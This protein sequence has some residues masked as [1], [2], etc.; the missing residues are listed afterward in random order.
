[1]RQASDRCGRDDGAGRRVARA[2][3]PPPPLVLAALALNPPPS[4][5]QSAPFAVIAPDEAAVTG[6]SGALPPPEIAPGDDPAALTFID[7]NGPSLRIVDLRAMGGP[8]SAQVVGAPKPFTFPRRADRAG[9]RRRARRCGAAERLCRGVVGL[10]AADRRA[11]AGRAPPA[12]PRRRPECGFHGR[13]LGRRRRSGLDL[14]DRR[15]DGP[16][17]QVRRRDDRRPAEFGGRARRPRLR[18]EVAVALRRRP[19]ERPHPSLRNGW[20]RA[21]QSTITGSPAAPPRGFRPRPGP[22]RRPSTLRTRNSTAAIPRPGISPSPE[23]RVFGLA[24]HDGRLYYAVADSLQVWSVGLMPDGAPGAD[25]IIE[26]MAPPA[27]GPTEISKIAFDGQGRML[28]AERAAP[29][30]AFDFEALAAPGIGRALRYAIVGAAAGRRVWQESPDEYA[31]GLSRR[32]SQRRRRRRRRRQLRPPRQCHRG[33]LRRVRLD[34]GRGPARLGRRGARG[35]ARDNG[36]RG[37]LRAAGGRRLADAAPERAAARKLFCQ[38][39]RRAARRHGARADGRHRDPQDLR[40][41]LERVSAARHAAARSCRRAAAGRLAART[42]AR[43]TSVAAAATAACAAPRRRRRAPAG[44]TRSGGSATAA[45]RPTCPRR[46]RPGR[47]PL[48]PGRDALGQ[49]R[50]ARIRAARRARPRSGRATSAATRARSMRGR[51]A[52]RP[53]ARARSSTGNAPAAAARADLSAR[54]SADRGMPVPERLRSDRRVVL[55]CE[56]GDL[57]RRLLPGGRVARRPEQEPVPA[58]FPYSDRPLVLRL[59]LDPDGERR[60]LRAGQRDDRRRLLS[61]PVDPAN[62]GS[63]P[64]QIQSRPVCAAGY[65]AMPDGTCCN[66]RFVG[67]DG[68]DVPDRAAAVR[69]GRNAGREG[70]LRPSRALPRR[71]PPRRR[72]SRRPPARPAKR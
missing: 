16:R 2:P 54:R 15:R 12:R 34:V 53:A 36:A 37:S 51:A 26:L 68:R 31:L 69:P 19:R 57:E 20:E 1:M 45:A 63:C 18:S 4:L 49:A 50:N 64:I 70:R 22:R 5:A 66:R 3:S 43:R 52:R 13:S 6:F 62:R 8:A 28:L 46:R 10:W 25:A 35:A 67:A 24:V 14:E 60:V 17:Q 32:L 41:R 21:W 55:P 33:R 40:R 71:A 48:L 47:R 72:F 58:D 42:A 27:A 61:V 44:R 7:P 39:R 23:R 65:V 59:G 30:G 29:T 56:P 11:R 38:L 9:V